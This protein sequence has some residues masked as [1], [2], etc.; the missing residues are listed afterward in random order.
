MPA[1]CLHVNPLIST[2]SPTRF[3]AD[4]DSGVVSCV[5]AVFACSLGVT[6]ANIYTVPKSVSMAKRKYSQKQTYMPY[7]LLLL[8]IN[9]C[10]YDIVFCSIV[11]IPLMLRHK[12]KNE[13]EVN[14]NVHF[15]RLPDKKN[16]M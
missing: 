4:I 16:I 6:Y 8:E 13:E 3:S 1:R 5:S 2:L 7:K 14:I 9:I 12:K 11:K 10:L 15:F